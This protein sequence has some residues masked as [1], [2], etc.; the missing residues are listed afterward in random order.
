MT[1]SQSF[2]RNKVGNIPLAL[3][4]IAF[5][6]LG[7]W[8][9][10][11][12]S[13][14]LTSGNLPAHPLARLILSHPTLSKALSALLALGSAYGAIRLIADFFD[15]TPGLQATSKGLIDAHYDHKEALGPIIWGDILEIY[16]FGADKKTL[17]VRV[18]DPDKYL[19]MGNSNRRSNSQKNMDAYGSPV[20]I[21]Q[22]YLKTSL[23]SV[24]MVCKRLHAANNKS[25]KPI[26]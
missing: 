2:E 6:V 16:V 5:A 25:G 14:Q 8:M 19:S 23:D 22:G 4:A 13:S 20:A 17:V 1:R 12:T 21:E 9:Y 26:D 7:C 15:K 11:N 18:A 10:I 24:A 3:L